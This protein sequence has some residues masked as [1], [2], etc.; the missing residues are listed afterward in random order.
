MRM[1]QKL[2]LIVMLLTTMLTGASAE[3]VTI[4]S[5]DGSTQFLPSYADQRPYCL[6]QQIYTAAEIGT[7]GIINSVAFKCTDVGA[8]RTL[9]IYMAHTAKNYFNSRTDW[10]TIAAADKVFSGSVTFTAGEWTTITLDTPFDYN[11]TDNLTI[12][13]NDKTGTYQSGLKFS[14][15]VPSEQGVS[16][17]MA[18]GYNV[19]NAL[20]PLE[21]GESSDS[22]WTVVGTMKNQIK[23][24]FTTTHTPVIIKKLPYTYGFENNN[25]TAEGWTANTTEENSGINNGGAAHH[26]GSYGFVFQGSETNASL[27]SPLLNSGDYKVWVK[28]WYKELYDTNEK[29]QV[30]YTTD[31]N[32]TNAANFIY[33]D[34]V[35]AKTDW[36]QYDNTF[37]AGTK[38]I[39]VK[40]ISSS[41]YFIVDDF[42]FEIPAIENVN[43]EPGHHTANVSWTGICDSYKVRYWKTGTNG[44]T[45][46]FENGL[47]Q[48]TI[49]TNNQ[50]PSDRAAGWFQ[51]NPKAEVYDWMSAH[52]G[53]YVASSCS[54][55]NVGSTSLNADN[56][57]ITPSVNLGG[58]VSFWV[59]A[60]E[61]DEYEV[62]LSTTGNKTS[63]FT[64][65]LRAMA[66]VTDK[67]MWFEETFDLT[68]YAGQKGYIAIHHKDYQEYYLYI[69]DFSLPNPL[70]N[71]IVTTGTSV[72]L[73][74]LESNTTYN[75]QIIGVKDGNELFKVNDILFTTKESLD[76]T[77]DT[78]NSAALA[79]KQFQTVDVALM[80]RTIYDN[81]RW[82]TICLPFAVDLTADG[83]LKGATAKTLE[84]VTVDGSSVTITFKDAGTTM[85]A[86]DPYF[87]LTENGVDNPVFENVEIEYVGASDVKADG[88][89]FRGTFF[90]VTLTAGSKNMLYLQNNLLY[91]PETGDAT[92][93]AFR[94]YI[95]LDEAVAAPM[96]NVILDMG[97][98][99]QT[100]LRQI[101]NGQ[102]IMD[103][104]GGNWYT[105]DGR[106]LLG[107]PMQK[108]VY[109]KDGKKVVIK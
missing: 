12:V 53:N 61:N 26:T 48:W 39:A 60:A 9:E 62:L 14:S 98:G 50:K 7:A 45:D 33:G 102:W 32:E 17:I 56:W 80:D 104:E 59:Y 42:S 87:V 89:T 16:S 25:L 30:G 75:M 37:P 83:P 74:G 43:V 54:W 69:D 88:A 108:G 106:Q 1:K 76:L 86:G 73:T 38:R 77:N 70:E 24:E 99:I 94:A 13:V 8:T 2:L 58:T 6:N 34:E 35:T 97:D 11:G 15:F 63:D 52:T 72:E 51:L 28:F 100:S 4:G 71:E 47:D 65:V 21:Y 90:P 3:V 20:I 55:Y 96:Q 64:T 5:G 67:E 109:V 22:H 82:N 23:L 105:L 46:S 93:N 19:Y 91:W 66:P 40:Y 36:Q 27:I 49:Y 79:S 95:Q 18:Y 31:E 68:A 57:L 107:K 85:K 103:N 44:I 101:D 78:D 81:T 29:F 10:V 92:I 84:S 41:N